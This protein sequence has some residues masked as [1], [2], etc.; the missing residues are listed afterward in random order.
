[1]QYFLGHLKKKVRNEVRD[2]TAVAG[3][4]TTLT[5]YYTSNTLA[6]L[7][8]SSLN[9]EGLTKPFLHLINCLRSISSILFQVTVGSCKFACLLEN[10]RI[11]DLLTFCQN[12]M[13]GENLALELWSKNL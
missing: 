2:L 3:S 13:P 11:N 10:E 5:I 8:I 7:T 12:Q 4:N 6:P 1:M 9:M